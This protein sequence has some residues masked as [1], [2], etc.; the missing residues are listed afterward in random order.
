[1]YSC[2]SIRGVI[3]SVH[4]QTVQKHGQRVSSLLMAFDSTIMAQPS[5]PY[6]TH[7]A[8]HLTNRTTETHVYGYL[9][10]PLFALLDVPRS[11][12]PW[13]IAPISPRPISERM[14]PLGGQ[15]AGIDAG[16]LPMG[17]SVDH[18]L[19]NVTFLA[20]QISLSGPCRSPVVARTSRPYSLLSSFARSSREV[21]FNLPS[22]PLECLP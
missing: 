3:E 16:K 6:K 19:E 22:D 11:S 15:Y 5:L 1:M 14:Q 4:P 7:Q 21:S 18:S 20:N 13:P 8:T 17:S 2:Y 12:L 10:D 9:L